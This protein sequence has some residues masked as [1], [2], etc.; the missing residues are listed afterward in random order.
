MTT[1]A[2]MLV[3]LVRFKLVK[4]I[5]IRIARMGADKVFMKAPPFLS[6]TIPAI[7]A[8]AIADQSFQITTGEAATACLLKSL[9]SLPL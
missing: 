6:R 1:V 2:T 3:G 8:K 4:A 7:P 5:P 9:L